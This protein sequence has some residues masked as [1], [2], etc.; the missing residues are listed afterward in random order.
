MKSKKV[1]NW[2]YIKECYDKFK[3]GN[4]IPEN[5]EVEFKHEGLSYWILPRN[6]G[7]KCTFLVKM[8]YKDG[9]IKDCVAFTNSYSRAKEKV[10]YLNTG[11]EHLSFD[12]I[13][14]TKL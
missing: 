5:E 3:K 8:R 12:I 13:S 1:E 4:N 14:V 7:G 10:E 11:S 6:R 2:D 9:E